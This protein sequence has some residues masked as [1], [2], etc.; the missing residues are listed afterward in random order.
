MLNETSRLD[1]KIDK[2]TKIFLNL[3]KNLTEEIQKQEIRADK[4]WVIFKTN[5]NNRCR[6]SVDVS[7]AETSRPTK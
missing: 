1:D 6:H 7:I 4:S 5:S 2:N 3:G